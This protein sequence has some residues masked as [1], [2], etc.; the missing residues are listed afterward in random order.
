METG[1]N[2]TGGNSGE[3]ISLKLQNSGIHVGI[4]LEY[5]DLAVS[6]P[7]QKGRGTMPDYEVPY[8]KKDVV[9]DTDT[10][11]NFVYGLIGGAK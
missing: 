11:L 4:P 7:A 9:A 2:Y 8:N 1:G 10:Q 6:P 5:Y 3:G